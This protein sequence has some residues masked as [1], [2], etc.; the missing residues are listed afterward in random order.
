[1]R[2]ASCAQ[3]EVATSRSTIA[4]RMVFIRKSL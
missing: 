4:R 3:L 1:M 2:A